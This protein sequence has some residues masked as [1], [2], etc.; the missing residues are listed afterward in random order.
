M[1]TVIYS[2][3][4]CNDLKTIEEVLKGILTDGYFKRIEQGTVLL[5]QNSQIDLSIE[6]HANSFYMS[7]RLKNSLL[8]SQSHI[9]EIA[10]ALKNTGIQFSLD[11]QEE[12]EEGERT[13]PEFNISNL[14][15]L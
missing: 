11:Y 6:P 13:T 1:E 9:V 12:N 3:I 2:T 10:N 4:Y 5:Y 8:N 7:G 14:S 15:D